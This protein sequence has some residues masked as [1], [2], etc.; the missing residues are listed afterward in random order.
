M[1]NLEKQDYGLGQRSKK[2]GL[3]EKTHEKKGLTKEIKKRGLQKRSKGDYEINGR[4]GID[5][6]K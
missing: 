1:F 4:K 5:K 2:R 6:C 3:G